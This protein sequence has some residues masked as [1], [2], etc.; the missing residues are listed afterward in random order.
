MQEDRADI[1]SAFADLG[2]RPLEA[3]PRAMDLHGPFVR[4]TD[5][6]R[7]Q[8]YDWIKTN[9]DRVAGR[10]QGTLPAMAVGNFGPAH[11]VARITDAMIQDQM[12]KA[13]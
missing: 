11:V 10:P 13:A 1:G 2:A 9:R 3:A 8:L 4:G 6:E 5:A 7:K 12:V